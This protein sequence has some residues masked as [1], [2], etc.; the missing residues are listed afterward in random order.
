M[1]IPLLAD[2]FG[3]SVNAQVIA[4]VKNALLAKGLTYTFSDDR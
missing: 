2:D 4:Y 1:I 3:N